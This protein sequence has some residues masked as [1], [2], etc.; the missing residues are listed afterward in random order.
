MS[1]EIEGDQLVIR[2]GVDT[3]S[4]AAQNCP[5]FYDHI[6]RK[7][8]PYVR[9]SDAHQLARSIR[10]MLQRED[11]SGATRLHKLLDDCIVAAW[12]DGSEGFEDDDA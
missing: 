10:G 7:Y 8:A 2:I 11:E 4:H 6:L 9:V 12:E 3:L 1:V 5:E